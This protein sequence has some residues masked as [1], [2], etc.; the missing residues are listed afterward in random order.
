MYPIIRI[1]MNL[2]RHRNDPPL[3]FGDTHVTHLVCRL[4]DI[5]VFREMNNGRTLTLYD[6]G[7]FGLFKRLGV[8]AVMARNNWAGTV[9]GTSVRYRH[10]VRWRDRIEMRSRIAGWDDKFVYIDQSMWVG[11]RATSQQ[12]IRTAVTDKNGLVRPA[13]LAETFGVEAK[14]PKMPD[15]ITAW[16]AAEAKR[17][18]PP[19]RGH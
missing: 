14:G 10:R 9:A 8:S 16:I 17:P 1:G 7:R 15:W 4:S 19:E 11:D 3:G 18:W 2:W 6:I 5:D 13:K 12:L